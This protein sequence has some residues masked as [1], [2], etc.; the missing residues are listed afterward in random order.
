MVLD[1]RNVCTSH[2]DS[3]SDQ[4][5]WWCGRPLQLQRIVQSS[6]EGFQRSYHHRESN[7]FGPSPYITKDFWQYEEWAASGHWLPHESLQIFSFRNPREVSCLK[8]VMS[9]ATN[10]LFDSQEAVREDSVRLG[11]LACSIDVVR[12][13]PIP[14]PLGR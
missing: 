12:V 7:R 1:L 9:C 10:A 2:A 3:C 13:I 14:K 11:P 5:V 8:S 4:G 6:G